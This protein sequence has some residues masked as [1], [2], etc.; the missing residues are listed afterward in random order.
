MYSRIL[1]PVDGSEL[2]ERA[3]PHAEG[4]A[5]SVGAT[6]YLLRVF[7]H[8][9][10]SNLGG[11]GLESAQSI[12]VTVE[13]VRQLEEAQIQE[14]Q[15]YLSRVAARLTS[16]GINVESDLSQGAPDEAIVDY[17]K[18]HGIDIITMSSHGRGGI[19]RFLLGSVTDRVIRSGT[20]PVLVVPC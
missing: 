15:E 18:Q 2:A 19:R 12:K 1:V 10:E 20:V 17:V 13:L 7:T 6:V 11:G 3:L 14:A 16:D 4:L 5:K 9:R 8:N